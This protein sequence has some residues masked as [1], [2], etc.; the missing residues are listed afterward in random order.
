M[1]NSVAVL[2]AIGLTLLLGACGGGE[3]SSVSEEISS[4]GGTVSLSDTVTL[5]IPPGA[6][7]DPTLVTITRGSDD[8][9]PPAGLE[10]ADAVGE[11]FNIDL[12]GQELAKPITLEIAFDPDL[13]RE[14]TPEDVIFL[15][16]YDQEKKE[17][18]P[19]GGQ[20]DEERNVVIIETDHLSWWNPF[21]WNWD[22]WIAILQQTL[23]LRISEWIDAVQ[24][25]TGACERSGQYATVDESDANSVIQG[26]IATDDASSPEFRIVNLKSFYLGISP[27][28]DGPGYPEATI[29]GPG[30][31]AHFTASIADEP[32]AVVYAD[33]TEAAMWRF[34]VG[35]VAR[36]LP[37]GDQIPNEGLV[38]IADGL[39]RVMSAQETSEA[40]NAGDSSG[41]AESLYELITGDTFIETF[42]MLAAE[43]GQD[44]GI[45]MMS[46]WTQS[47]IRQVFLGVA[48]VDVIIS[49]TDFLA[50]YIFNNHS[51][52]AFSWIP[53]P[54][55]LVTYDKGRCFSFDYPE[56][57][58]AYSRGPINTDQPRYLQLE[59]V[60]LTPEPLSGDPFNTVGN[61]TWFDNLSNEV[62]WLGAG[63][64]GQLHVPTTGEGHADSASPA[65]EAE[66]V[67][68]DGIS[69]TVQRSAELSNGRHYSWAAFDNGYTY[70]GVGAVGPTADFSLLQNVLRS[71]RIRC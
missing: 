30:D 10:A 58:N 47:G 29:L 26:C 23:S 11:A 7:A 12:G 46:T 16:F 43:Y 45:D 36:M 1:R 59:D 25:L 56:E 41:A 8:Q 67:T 66:I 34:V 3:P 6:L 49:A 38:F 9:P 32:P 55:E 17:W 44:H 42:T 40:L 70:F 21:E 57:L 51:E 68:A 65:S 50:N 71:L 2:I 35:L 20:V 33:F 39:Q 52:L 64:I 62:I 27:A 60:L 54:P 14:D 19:A 61:R 28:A 24:L 69:V 15:A 37:A 22:A 4:A 18:V 53:P 5:R 13:V 48:A 63:R 31:A